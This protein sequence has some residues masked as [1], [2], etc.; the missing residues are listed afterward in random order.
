[1]KLELGD[2]SFKLSRIDL[3]LGLNAVPGLSLF[4]KEERD[5]QIIKE[6]VGT[7]DKAKINWQEKSLEILPYG[8]E[9]SP[10]SSSENEAILYA[11][12]LEKDLESWFT[13]KPEADKRLHYGIYQNQSDIGGWSFLNNCLGQKVLIPPKNYQER[14]DQILPISTCMTRPIRQDNQQYLDT[15]INY[16][17]HHLPELIGW[18][19]IHSA[20]EPLRFIF[21]DQENAIKLNESWENLSARLPI[22]FVHSL[23]EDK[24]QT[25]QNWDANQ[26][27]LQN[28]T[29]DGTCQAWCCRTL[30]WFS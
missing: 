10:K 17:Q 23:S 22:R 28:G 6:I 3:R 13:T 7:K 29:L 25:S 30:E 1:M 26:N 20:E 12:L 14:I 27:R 11:V 16:L 21:M 24:A 18:S 5:A 9:D 15:V 4:L 2:N 8:F 19:A